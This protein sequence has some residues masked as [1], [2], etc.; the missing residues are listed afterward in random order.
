MQNKL[1]HPQGFML[2]SRSMLTL[3]SYVMMIIVLWLL[4][5]TDMEPVPRTV[6][7]FF[8]TLFALWMGAPSI[9]LGHIMWMLGIG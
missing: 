7:A 9:I 8:A 6:A 5:S 4:L 3:T 2:Q 1:T